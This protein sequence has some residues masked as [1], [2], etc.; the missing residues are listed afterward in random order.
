MSRFW[1]RL[2]ACGFA[3]IL[4]TGLLALVYVVPVLTTEVDP[5]LM[6]GQCHG[7]KDWDMPGSSC[8]DGIIFDYA[9]PPIPVPVLKQPSVNMVV[10][11]KRHR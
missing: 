11:K 2:L 3:V 4:G 6:K 1:K 9:L 7:G 8:H 5:N 10:R